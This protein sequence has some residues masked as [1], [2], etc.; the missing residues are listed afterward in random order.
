MISDSGPRN[1]ESVQRSSTQPENIS[2]DSCSSNS[3]WPIYESE[4]AEYVDEVDDENEMPFSFFPLVRMRSII[5]SASP[6]VL[7]PTSRFSTV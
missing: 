5:S 3:A 1:R 7:I 4:T 2:F 6:I